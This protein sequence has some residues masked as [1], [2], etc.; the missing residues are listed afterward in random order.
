M[1]ISHF[2]TNNNKNEEKKENVYLT[3]E[4]KCIDGWNICVPFN[5]RKKTELNERKKENGRM[6]FFSE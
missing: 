5:N 6:Y 3:T 1:Q 4:R 2:I